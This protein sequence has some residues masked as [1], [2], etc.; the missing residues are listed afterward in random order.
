LPPKKVVRDDVGVERPETRYAWNGDI[1]LAHQVMGDGPID[2]VYLQGYLSNI[3]L[4]WEHPALAR[5]LRELSGFS[6]L[7]VTDR[8]GLGCS[9]RFTPPDTPPIETLVDDVQAV[10]DSVGS[11][12]PVLLAT[13]DCGFL[14]VL[15]AATHPERLTA[16]VLYGSS[17]RWTR[18]DDTPWGLTKEQ[19][20]ADLVSL[21][22]GWGTGSW[23]CEANPS[24]G[25]D[26]RGAEWCARYERCSI[27]P[28]AAY[29]EA[30]RFGETDVRGVLRS[31]QVP[32][33][34]LHRTDDP[35]HWVDGSRYLAAHIPA[36]TF[37]ELDGSDHFPWAGDQGSVLREVER[38]LVALRT[39]EADLDRVL[40]TVL[41]TDIVGSTGKVAELGD[42][43]WRDLLERHHATVR[44]LLAR[45]R[46][47]EIDTAGDG[48]FAS[49]DGPARGV[50][51]AHAIMESLRPLGLGVRAG[52][53]TGEV[54]TIGGKVGGIAV[55]IGA[56]VGAM[57]RPSEVLV[58]QTVK[59]LVAGSGLEFEDRGE[60]VLKGVPGEW[61]LFAASPH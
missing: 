28:G 39:E 5:F 48:F 18:S 36:A 4:N 21:R 58:S 19:L 24:L 12:R 52:L 60:H 11:E 3:E 29:S 2:L 34:V 30:I 57:A 9:E 16:L 59:D 42:A 20:E 15:F 1:A 26:R 54:E 23:A 7:I 49:F 27:A 47:R 38:F 6:R 32:T 45:Y 13:G 35:E 37:V 8:R 22:A 51:C 61:R 14:A 44:A 43:G 17:P 41:F 55:S 46:G 53:H 33:L 25:L 50:Q 40:A 10:L 56:R 31:I